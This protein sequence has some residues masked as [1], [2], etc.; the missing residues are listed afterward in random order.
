MRV[1]E[2]CSLGNIQ[3]PVH[4]GQGLIL[5]ADGEEAVVDPG[6]ALLGGLGSHA[7]HAASIQPIKEGLPQALLH[8]LSCMVNGLQGD[9]S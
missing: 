2:H 7:G 6:Q 3:N 1:P 9:Q 4:R 5:V 8:Q